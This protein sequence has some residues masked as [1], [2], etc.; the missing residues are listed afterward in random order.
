MVQEVNSEENNK[1][2]RTV[3][4]TMRWFVS[5]SVELGQVHWPYNIKKI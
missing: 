3:I 5:S 4:H 2:N 1:K